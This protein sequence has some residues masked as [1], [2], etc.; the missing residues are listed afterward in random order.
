MYMVCIPSVCKVLVQ[1]EP[2]GRAGRIY[3]ALIIDVTGLN[4]LM[5]LTLAYDHFEAFSFKYVVFTC[6]EVTVQVA[7][8]PSTLKA[9]SRTLMNWENTDAY[10]GHDQN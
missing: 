8:A 7:L 1:E 3:I 10:L 2:G 4:R 5:R 9:A 6:T